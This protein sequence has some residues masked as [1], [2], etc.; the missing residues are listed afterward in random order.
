MVT[1]AED[2]KINPREF[3]IFLRCA[4]EAQKEMGTR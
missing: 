2:V 4:T 3:M 1:E